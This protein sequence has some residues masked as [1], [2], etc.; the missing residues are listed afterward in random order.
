M[1]RVCADASRARP[2]RDEGQDDVLLRDRRHRVCPG[3]GQGRAHG[4]DVRIGGV[5]VIRQYLAAGQIDEMHLALS[6]V[7]MG[8]G[9][10]LFSPINLHQLGFQVAERVAGENATHVVMRR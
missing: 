9:E 5:S 10:H 7:L 6:P 3:A 8:E 1:A 2:A 4:K